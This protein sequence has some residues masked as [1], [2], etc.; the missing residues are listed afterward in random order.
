MQAIRQEA[1]GGPEQLRMVEIERPTPGPTEVLVRVHA[2]GVNPVD[3][4]ARAAPTMFTSPPFTLGW[5]VSGVVE[6]VAIG[7]NRFAPGDEVFGMP[8]FPLEAGCYA[9]FTTA[10]ARQLA[11]KPAR[12]THIEA[13][14]LP[15]AGLTAWQIL[16]DVA[17]VQPGHRVLVTAAGGGVGHLAVQIAKAR[18]AYVIGTARRD[19]HDL[20]RR[21]GADEVIDYTAVDV[22]ESVTD[23]DVAIDLVGGQ[24][25]VE[26]VRTLSPGGLLIPVTRS[27]DPAIDHAAAARGVRIARFLVEPDQ[28]GLDG[29]AR[30]VDEGHLRVVV[31][32]VLPL[33]EAAK[34]HQMGE[35][36]RT[37]GKIVLVP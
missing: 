19:K 28:V 7:V 22:A 35:A 33:A 5:D 30:L 37:Q 9:E 6:E 14:G 25:S 15:L 29:L 32:T 16:V 36:G 34:A 17:K 26:L 31:D 27:G 24:S 11:H 18:G 23:L 12:L 1:F 8:R 21:L 20:L 2:A 10:P 13:G 3:W 4:K